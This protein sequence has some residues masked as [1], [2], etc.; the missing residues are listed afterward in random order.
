MPRS[1][2]SHLVHL[3]LLLISPPDIPR[4]SRSALRESSTIHQTRNF[5]RWKASEAVGTVSSHD[6]NPRVASPPPGVVRNSSLLK[7]Q[8]S[9]SLR[10]R[11]I[12]LQRPPE[13]TVTNLIGNEQDNEMVEADNIEIQL[14]RPSMPHA[15][16]RL[17]VE[18]TLIV[19][20]HAS[21]QLD[22]GP[23][24]S[25]LLRA[26]SPAIST[27][28]D[29]SSAPPPSPIIMEEAVLALGAFSSKPVEEIVTSL[30]GNDQDNG[31]V[32]EENIE[33]ERIRLSMLHASRWS[34]PCFD[35]A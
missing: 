20:D 9:P 10:S 33:V 22:T 7:E 4:A 2:K 8:S 3:L 15:S 14:I 30:V 6:S 27:V 1:L 5:A 24:V 23:T 28:S 17:S 25:G 31:M 19:R 13:E 32:E 26:Y 12:Q 11:S 16:G 18:S 35:A 21:T 34:I 29:A